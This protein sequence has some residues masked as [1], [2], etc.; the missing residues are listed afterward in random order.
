[1][2]RL[3]DRI[4]GDLFSPLSRKYKAIYAFALVCLYRCLR[5][6]KTDIKRSDYVS[7]L[8]GQGQELLDL[9]SVEMDQLDDKSD[10]EKVAPDKGDDDLSA[11]I[12]YVVRKLS[13]CGWFILSKN[14]KTGVEYIYIPAYSIQLL[15][16]INDLTTDVGTYLPLV[17]QTYAELKMED[18]KED[19][20]MYRSLLNARSNADS[21]EMSVTL[22]KQQI[23]VFG[24][25]LTSVLDPNT[26]HS[27][28]R[29]LPRKVPANP[30]ILPINYSPKLAI[31]HSVTH[32]PSPK[33][34]PP[35]NMRRQVFAL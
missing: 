22:L 25:R 16:L 17:H 11:K 24:N 3:F 10:E 14:A 20:Y 4:P 34:R 7:L 26:I 5:L 31:T 18:E 33:H 21:I 9:F 19:D 13:S 28:L 8:K 32:R 23:C 12:S 6:Y 30:V 35:P 29:G 27:H 1:M 15:K 2:A